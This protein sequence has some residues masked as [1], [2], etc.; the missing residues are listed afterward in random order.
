A[1]DLRPVLRRE[2]SRIRNVSRDLE[3]VLLHRPSIQRE[4]GVLA[5]LS[6][7]ILIHTCTGTP[8][9][10]AFFWYASHCAGMTRIII[11]LLS[12]SL[13]FSGGLPAFALRPPLDIK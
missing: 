11:C 2:R 3:P 12:R 8:S 7:A 4:P 13:G 6:S 5:S 1:L 10:A 9:L